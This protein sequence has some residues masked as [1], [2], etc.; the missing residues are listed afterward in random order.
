M[1]T[2]TIVVEATE[3][4]LIG[5]LMAGGVGQRVLG[6]LYRTFADQLSYVQ[7]DTHHTTFKEGQRSVVQFLTNAVKAAKAEEGR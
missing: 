4:K 6:I 7:G 2:K 1:E 3:A 5:Q